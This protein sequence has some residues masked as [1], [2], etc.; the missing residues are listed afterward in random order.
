MKKTNQA[1]Q[2]GAVLLVALVMLLV[3]TVLAVTSMRGV[4][5][6]SRITGN[7]AVM[8]KLQEQA[9][10]ALREGEYRYFGNTDLR[11]KLE[12]HAENCQI[13]NQINK[14]CLLKE[15]HAES[16]DD[17]RTMRMDFLMGPI[18][19]FEKHPE[20]ASAYDITKGEDVVAGKTLAWMPYRGLGQ[21][22]ESFE[23]EAG[24]R[25]YWNSYLITSSAD[26]S[27]AFN[28]EYGNVMEGRGTYY[29]L[30]NGQANDEIV[31]QSTFGNIYLGLNN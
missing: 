6:E 17:T 26:E 8:Q 3:L 22:N 30:V 19:F 16:L 15:M 24:F 10:A 27:E 21:N 9:D 12:F 18:T 2:K 31:L 14:P 5:M 1:K 25:S 11:N 7:R 28:S 23:S 13:N 4:V 20:Y 29:Y